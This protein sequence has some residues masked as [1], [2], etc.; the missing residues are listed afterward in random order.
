MELV[1]RVPYLF[2]S[3]CSWCRFYSALV[4][5]NLGTWHAAL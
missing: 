4:I 1:F 2:G 3:S 5:Q